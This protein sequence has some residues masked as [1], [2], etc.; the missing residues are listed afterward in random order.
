MCYKVRRSNVVQ[1]R[2]NNPKQVHGNNVSQKACETVPQPKIHSIV[3]YRMALDKVGRKL[4]EF[5][6]IHE[7]V[8][9]IANAMEGLSFLAHVYFVCSCSAF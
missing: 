8:T 5:R 4:I 3:Y 9:A 7:L 1:K 2:Y 6:S